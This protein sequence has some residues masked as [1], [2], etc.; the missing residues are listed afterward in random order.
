MQ[1]LAGNED[2]RHRHR[3]E[4][5]HHNI[6][7]RQ[8]GAAVVPHHQYLP[9]SVVSA[10]QSHMHSTLALPFDV[11]DTPVPKAHLNAHIPLQFDMFVRNTNTDSLLAPLHKFTTLRES[12]A[13]LAD[14]QISD[15]ANIFRKLPPLAS[16]ETDVLYNTQIIMAESTLKLMWGSLA[17]NAELGIQFELQTQ[18]SCDLSKYE[19]FR[20]STRFFEA[21]EPLGDATVGHIEYEQHFNRLGNVQ[22][23]SK[24]WAGKVMEVARRLHKAREHRRKAQ[25]S[26]DRQEAAAAEESARN[27]EFEIR[28][29]FLSLTA[30]QELTAKQQGS[31]RKV[32]LLLVCW[33]FEQAARDSCG[34][35]TWRNIIIMPPPQQQQILSSKDEQPNHEFEQMA[36]GLSQ[37][38][39]SL[40]L[41]S[42]FEPHHGFDLNDLSTA[43]L[44][45]MASNVYEPQIYST[46][47]VDFTGDH[48]HM[49][50]GPDVSVAPAVSLHSFHDPTHEVSN[51]QSQVLY[52]HSEQW[53]PISYPSSYLEHLS[54]FSQLRAFPVDDGHTTAQFSGSIAHATTPFYESGAH[55]TTSFDNNVGN[56]TNPFREGDHGGVEAGASHITASS[57][58]PLPSIEFMS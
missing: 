22:F 9:Q 4:R 6:Y 57:E 12:G 46:N 36:L 47:N 45:G 51:G 28:A 2:N 49:C 33:K 1:H 52:E 20:C 15:V 13:K 14:V 42:P 17:K 25:V 8:I 11:L 38:Q 16:V 43:T 31:R 27:I 55:A 19:D 21:G 18:P 40:T 32:T 53:Q 10:A 5:G 50:L 35:T 23:G 39:T 37:H 54:A 48:I 29:H 34:E 7:R 56:G 30:L 41:Q 24:F 44:A 3:H 26:E 58:D